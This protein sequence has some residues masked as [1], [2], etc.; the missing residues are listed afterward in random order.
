MKYDLSIDSQAFFPD[1]LDGIKWENLH[2][3]PN[4]TDVERIEIDK[5]V[6]EEI[7]GKKA[8]HPTGYE[9]SDTYDCILDQKNVDRQVEIIKK[10]GRPG[11]LWFIRARRIA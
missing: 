7:R 4:S 1:K 10:S 11:L 5:V 8:V 3:P 2:Y 6:N 9:F